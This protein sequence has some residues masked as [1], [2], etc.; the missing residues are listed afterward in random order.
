MVTTAR[1]SIAGFKIRDGYPIGCGRDPAPRA[2][3][4]IPDRLITIALPRVRDFRGINGKSF[5]G[6][7][8]YNMVCVSRSFSGNRVRQDRCAARDEHH[9]HHYR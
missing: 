1:K 9:H 3:V 7:G 5:D 6:R 2:H 4:R 8:N